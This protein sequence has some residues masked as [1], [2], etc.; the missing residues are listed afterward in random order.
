MPFGKGG[1]S[2]KTSQNRHAMFFSGFGHNAEKVLGEGPRRDNFPGFPQ[3]QPGALDC[4]VAEWPCS[5]LGI[6]KEG[7]YK[8]CASF[9][10]FT[11]RK[12]ILSLFMHFLQWALVSTSLYRV[13]CEA[14]GLHGVNQAWAPRAQVLEGHSLKPPTST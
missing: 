12:P 11:A 8:H 2:S 13:L 10:L 14:F 6:H 4:G 9:P 5:L 1:A 7:H 3:R